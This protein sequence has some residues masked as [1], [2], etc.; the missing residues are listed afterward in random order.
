M[1]TDFKRGD[2]VKLMAFLGDSNPPR[3][4]NSH[5][6]YWKLIGQTGTVEDVLLGAVKVLVKFD[7]DIASWGLSCHNPIPNTLRI[8]ISDLGPHR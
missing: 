3:K 5:E 7:V 8:E 6:N 2:R 4:C 1:N